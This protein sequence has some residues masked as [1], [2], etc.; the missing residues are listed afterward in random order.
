MNIG[1][2]SLPQLTSAGKIQANGVNIDVGSNSCPVIVDWNEDGKKD[3]V[4]GN[5]ESQVRVYLNTGSNAAP[6]F[7]NYTVV[8]SGSN[9]YRCSPEVCDLN[10]DGKKDLIIGENEGYVS[11]YE[12][13]GSNAAPSFAS[14]GERLKLDNGMDLKVSYGAHIDLIDWDSNGSMDLLIGDYDAYLTLFINPSGD[15]DDPEQPSSV[16]A[17]SDYTTPTAMALTWTDP[18]ALNN[19]TPISPAEFTIEI[20]RDSI[21]ITSIPGGS[22]QYNDTG[23]NDG[24][25]YQYTLKTKLVAN[26]STS[27]PTIAFWHAGGS[28]IPAAPSN[29]TATGTLTQADLSWTDPT[30]QEDGTPLDDLDSIFVYRNGIRIANVAPGVQAYSD[31]PPAGFV[32]NYTTTAIDNETPPNESQTSNEARVFVGDTP[33]F[34]VWVGPSAMGASAASGDS[35]FQSLVDNGEST[36]LTNNLFEFGNNLSI[37]DAIFVVLGIFANNHVILATDPEGPALESFIQSGGKLYLE[38]GDCFNYDPGIGGYNSGIF[39]N[40]FTNSLELNDGTTLRKLPTDF[41]IK[42]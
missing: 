1:S 6:V 26:D 2:T 25:Y 7:T 17:Y 10:R 27:M 5:Q 28:P 15:A 9:L 13:I 34:M 21:W 38:G 31:T 33:K 19:G 3:L 39:H 18:T 12:N 4:V 32:Y 14:T 37:Y 8:L 30:T 29:L 24:Q 36:F 42:F 41:N 40:K 35:I 11:F 16:V 23:L 20:E 22:E